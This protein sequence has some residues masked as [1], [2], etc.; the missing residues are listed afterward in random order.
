MV[1]TGFKNWIEKDMASFEER[2]K[3]SGRLFQEACRFLPGGDTRSALF[4]TPYPIYMDRGAGCYFLDVDGNRYL[5]F[6]NNYTAL[7]HG[8]V[9]PAIVQAVQEQIGKGSSFAAPTKNQCTLAAL[10]C[11]R[12]RSVEQV[13]FCNSGTEA[14]MHAI[15]AAR[16]ISGRSKVVKI[17]GGYHGTHDLAE[18]SYDPGDEESGP[19]EE[20]RSV[21]KNRGV[22]QSVLDEVIVIPFNNR[23]ISERIIRSHAREIACVIVEPMLGATGCV[24]QEDGFLAFLRALTA[25][26]NILLIFDE[27]VTFRLGLGGAQGIYGVSPDLTTFGKIIG[28]GFPVG[29][30]GGPREI[31]KMY[32]P[33]EKRNIAHSGTFNGNPVTM[34]AGIACLEEL[35]ENAIERINSF[36]AILRKGIDEVFQSVGI[37][38]FATG[39]GS[40]ACIHFNA[41]PVRDYRTAAMDNHD[42]MT[43]VHLKLLGKGVNVPRRGGELSISTPMT[44]LEVST[45]LRVFEE[46]VTEIKPYIE[47]SAQDLVL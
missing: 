45:F 28:G 16:I 2:T 37:R 40:L 30:F 19:I 23:E 38:G 5:D 10:I 31:M 26:L 6:L 39:M 14:T 33:L 1:K 8:H 7:I 42:A 32:S 20:P 29:A 47:E 34:A 35:T 13:R 25:E 36:G 3:G 41:H 18:I 43:L 21:P 9:H 11:E 44:E 17:E 4:F 46:S 27:I 24:V 15:R 22:P 12:V